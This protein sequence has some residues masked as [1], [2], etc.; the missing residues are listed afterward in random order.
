M[1]KATVALGM[2]GGVDSSVAVHLL[3]KAGY[4]VIGITMWLIP[5]EFGGSEASI[6]DARMVAAQLG[7]VHHVVDFRRQFAQWIIGDFISEYD[8][9]RTPNPCILCNQRIK[10][11]L[12]QQSARQFGSDKMATGHYAQIKSGTNGENILCKGKDVQK[13]QSYFLCRIPRRVLNDTIFPLG[14]YHKT[15]IRQLANQLG[16]SIA[17]KPDSQEVC[18]IADNDYKGFLLKAKKVSTFQK[19]QFVDIKGNLLGMHQGIQCHT[20][21]QRKGLGLALGRPVYVVDIDAQHNQVVI[22]SE[23]DLYQTALLADQCSWLYNLPYG[24]PLHIQ[25]KVRYRAA[26][27]AAQLI[28]GTDQQA[29]VI[30]T[31]P[32]RAITPGQSVCFYWGDIVLGGGRIVK[33]VND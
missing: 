32:Q 14:N 8:Q 23:E 27:E 10:F 31:Q 25:A 18:F 28:I 15:E 7:I 11:G 13:D 1:K 6:H 26:A 2:S 29:K 24:V 3:Q 16:L 17:D 20:I 19:G 22:G 9:G 12:L 30:F 21:G 4:D 5:E 33:S